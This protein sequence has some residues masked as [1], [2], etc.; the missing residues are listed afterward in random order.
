MKT[1]VAATIISFVCASSAFAECYGDAAQA[2]G[3]GISRGN[4]ATLE[5]FGDSRNEVQP[6][7]GYSRPIRASDL[8]SEQETIGLYRRLYSGWHG[9]R[10]S[11]Q[12][13]RNTI[14]RGTQPV[15]TFGNLPFS[16]PMY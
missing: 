14:N 6:D 5:S 11:E 3:C 9:N 15:R 1:I 7:Y 8:F 10:W 13:F 2:F 12:T 4:E 16:N